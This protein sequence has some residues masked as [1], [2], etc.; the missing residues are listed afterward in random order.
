MHA[1]KNGGWA[2]IPII[3][4]CLVAI[5]L[6]LVAKATLVWYSGIPVYFCILGIPAIIQI[7]MNL[8]GV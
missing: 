2:I 1:L 7:R 6:C 3:I 5:V 4:I 8:K